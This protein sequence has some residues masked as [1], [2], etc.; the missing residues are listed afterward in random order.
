MTIVVQMWAAAAGIGQS[1]C[2]RVVHATWAQPVLAVTSLAYVVVGL[3]VLASA[4]RARGALA[5]AAGVVLVAVGAGSVI[6]HGPQPP[7][8]GTAHDWPIIAMAVVYVAGL[9]FTV[10]REW[11]VWLAAAAILAIALIAYVAGRSGSPLCR[12][13]SPWQFHGA[14]H[15]LSAA[16][17][18]LAAMVMARHAVLARRESARR[19]AAG[20]Q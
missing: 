13:D 9:A 18:G 6:Y 10:R 7:W 16:A 1:D 2:E 8:A 19:D 11:R 4:V 5:A 20:G 17:A 15:V 3:A 14:W 12:P